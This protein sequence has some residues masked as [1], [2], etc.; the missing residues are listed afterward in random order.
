MASGDVVAVLT[1]PRATATLSA[2]P[3]YLAGGSSP[4]ETWE[5]WAFD[6]STIWYLDFG[7]TLKGYD[8]GGV[9]VEFSWSAATATSNNTV[10]GC[11]FRRIQDNA[12]TALSASHSYA[13][14][15]VTSS[16]PTTLNRVQKDSITFSNGVD[17][18]SV[19]NNEQF[20]LRW[21]RSAT[22]ASDTMAGNAILRTDLAVI[23]RET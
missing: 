13:Y 21:R 6:A 12:G 23:V 20:N 19:G 1:N 14:N 10:W 5:G 8:G 4:N 11:A 3:D 2:I 16:C 9:T 7:G 18:G 17:M 15:E 22:D